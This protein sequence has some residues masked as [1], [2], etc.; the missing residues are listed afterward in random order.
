MTRGRPL[1]GKHVHNPIRDLRTHAAPFVSVGQLAEYWGYHAHT[2]H[3]W[4]RCGRL[5]AMRGSE[6]RVRTTDALALEA[7]LY[8]RSL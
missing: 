8:L 4:V 6:Y 2:I 7:E 3:R 1:G 5:P